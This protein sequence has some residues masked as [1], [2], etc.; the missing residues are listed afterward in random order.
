MK[1]IVGF[2][3]SFIAPRRDNWLATVGEIL[4][5]PVLNYGI[6]GS[7]L[8][9]SMVAFADYTV[10]AE[11]DP[12]DIII[13]V[14]TEDSRIYTDDMPNPDMGMFYKW[15][16]LYGD[17]E[18]VNE[19]LEGSLWHVKKV[20]DPKI[21]FEMIKTLCFFQLWA[22]THPNTVLVKS[23]YYSYSRSKDF[24]SQLFSTE[25]FL[26]INDHPLH[27]LSV[28]EF[29][30]HR[31]F[32]DAIKTR[33]IRTNHLCKENRNTLARL[34]ANVISSNSIEE[35]DASQFVTGVFD[36]D[37]KSEKFAQII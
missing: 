14:P 5:L 9:Y 33:D 13:F 34:L 6:S 32:L 25:N 30:D 18:W 20:L 37:I 31:L 8:S 24:M 27:E 26:L 4:N 35:Y 17:L 15:P 1:K 3:D 2:G 23:I 29:S 12:E 22:M 21:N 36:S 28:S 11:Y 7:S 16:H 19:N 10:S